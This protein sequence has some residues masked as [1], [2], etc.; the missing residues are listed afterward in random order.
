MSD[1]CAKQYKCATSL[2]T[3]SFLSHKYGIEIHKPF[4]CPGHGKSS[5]DA[6]SGTDKGYIRN[7]MI[8]VNEG[9]D[10]AEEWK[11]KMESFAVDGDGNQ[12]SFSKRLKG[13][14][15][16]PERKYGAKSFIKSNKRET[17]R[18]VRKRFYYVS[19]YTDPSVNLPLKTH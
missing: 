14:L 9:G 6:L 15:A 4:T 12:V 17:E 13:L 18:V 11:K 8:A 10:D 1:N 3:I 2:W 19:D 5:V 16:D 7:C